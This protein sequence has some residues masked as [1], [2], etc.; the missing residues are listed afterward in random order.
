MSLEDLPHV[1]VESPSDLRAWF[2]QNH[3]SSGSVWLVTHKKSS[4]AKYVST[5]VVLDEVLSFGWVDGIRR[6]RDDATTMQVISP[7]QTL[8]WTQSYRDRASR[9]IESGQM[10]P[11]GMAQIHASQAAGKWESSAPVDALEIPD[12]LLAALEAEEPAATHFHAYPPSYRRNVLRWIV[13]AKREETRAK[14]IGIVCESSRHNER[15]KN[16]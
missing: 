11:A 6:K 15:M 4:P 10:T 9:L 14:R 2:E 16:F 3:A 8:E 1:H 12:D 7:R 5:D 13:G